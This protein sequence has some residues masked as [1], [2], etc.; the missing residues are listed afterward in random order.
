MGQPDRA[1]TLRRL[2]DDERVA[3][4]VM[5]RVEA[6]IPAYANLTATQR[7]ETHAIARW[8]VRRLVEMWV[9]E[10]GLSEAD[11]RRFHGIGVARA[12]DGRPL[13]AVLR[14]YRVAA[15]ETA[16]LI[17]EA[18]GE[19]LS[20][21]DVVALNRTL[22]TGVEDLSEALF[23][24]YT[25]TADR[26]ADDRG[27]S[28]SALTHDLLSGRH[29]SR[30]ALRDRSGQLG[31]V[32]P[33][34]LSVLVAAPARPAG[35]LTEGEVA[36]F[37]AVVGDVPGPDPDGRVVMHARRDGAA[38]VLTPST[39]H[40]ADDLRFR[41]WRG[42]AVVATGTDQVP[43]AYRLALNAVRTAPAE[44]TAARDVLGLA[45]ALYLALLV[46]D[47]PASAAEL[48]AA[49]LGPLLQPR[50]AHLLEGLRAYLAHGSATEAAAALGLHPQTMRHRL[51]RAAQVSGRSTTSAW[52]TLLV[53]TSLMALETT[54][55]R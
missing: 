49:T 44:A 39:P 52:D 5:A 17:V 55:G 48:A 7:Q 45:D 6:Q 21:D 37:A 30:D 15:V 26:L 34:Q 51:R 40:V 47:P 19:A 2:Q 43:R 36:D 4:R 29:V 53:H 24:G 27:R 3:A 12:T 35:P 32:V 28:M 33:E 41:A 18:A 25:V 16:D 11:R 9:D 20:V 23:A 1:A 13:L 8:A 14:A 31:V 42:C 22:L 10:T 38:V 54:P 46:G 50:H